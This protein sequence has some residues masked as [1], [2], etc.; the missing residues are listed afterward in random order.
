MGFIVMSKS[1]QRIFGMSAVVVSLTLI[2]ALLIVGQINI[3]AATQE[4]FELPADSPQARALNIIQDE[5]NPRDVSQFGIN[6]R[7]MSVTYPIRG[8]HYM[9]NISPIATEMELLRITCQ[10]RSAGYVDQ[11][12]RFLIT[13]PTKQ[14]EQVDGYAIVLDDSTVEDLDCLNLQDVVVSEIA[15]EYEFLYIHDHKD[16]S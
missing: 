15:D 6:D 16:E 1:R 4:R 13:M 9:G 11:T 2:Y 8:S 5:V 12:F 7:M 10:L 3:T 14:G